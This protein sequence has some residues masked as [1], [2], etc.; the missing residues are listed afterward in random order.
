MTNERTFRYVV[1]SR[2]ADYLRLGWLI[3]ADLGHP[4]NQWSVLAEWVCDCPL[5]EP[6]R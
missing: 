6:V 5:K 4:H 2:I 1:H 3:V